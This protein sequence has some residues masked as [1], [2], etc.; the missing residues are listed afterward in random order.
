VRPNL[1]DRVVLG[2]AS[3]V[4]YVSG[5]VTWKLADVAIAVGA[6]VA[7]WALAR[8]LVP[9]TWGSGAVQRAEPAGRPRGR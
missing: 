7:T 6:L 1:L 9:L 2:G 5:R 8:C 3:D 4:L